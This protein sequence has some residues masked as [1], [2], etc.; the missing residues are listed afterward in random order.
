MLRDGLASAKIGNWRYH[1]WVPQPS[2][3]RN[4]ARL[5]QPIRTPDEAQDGCDS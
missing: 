5:P 4:V 2:P 3:L 1:Y